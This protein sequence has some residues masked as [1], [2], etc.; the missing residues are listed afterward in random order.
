MVTVKQGMSQLD[1]VIASAGSL[2][3][4]FAFAALNGLGYS[5]DVETGQTLKSTGLIYQ[6][7]VPPNNDHVTVKPVYPLQN[8][9][10][11][12]MAIQQLGSIEAFFA[13]A[14]LNGMAFSDDLVAG[15]QLNYSITPFNKAV[16]KTY[17]DNGYKPAT[18]KQVAPETAVLQG[19]GYWMIGL[20]FIVS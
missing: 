16:L 3:D 5:D 7:N 8:Q 4:W 9:T 10:L 15:E 1:A 14:N 18:G 2:E 12:D 17:Q 13:L 11:M 20:N 19:I 6:V